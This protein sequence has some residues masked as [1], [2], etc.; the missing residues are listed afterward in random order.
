MSHSFSGEIKWGYKRDIQ[1][2]IETKLVGLV[3]LE[4]LSCEWRKLV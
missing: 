4:S 3:E 1:T 2:E